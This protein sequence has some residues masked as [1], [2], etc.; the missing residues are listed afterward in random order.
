M[1]YPI[2]WRLPPLPSPVIVERSS[3]E[4][5]EQT[6]SISDQISNLSGLVKEALSVNGSGNNKRI[7]NNELNVLLSK[8]DSNMELLAKNNNV[9]EEREGLGTDKFGQ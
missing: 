2:S 3:A 8:I 5:F 7:H 6:A 9:G 1:L 4:I